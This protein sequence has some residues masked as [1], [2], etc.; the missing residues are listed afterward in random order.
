M[1]CAVQVEPIRMTTKRASILAM[2]THE[3]IT[4]VAKYAY[5]DGAGHGQL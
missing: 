3:L 2:I 1:R 5:P 4:N